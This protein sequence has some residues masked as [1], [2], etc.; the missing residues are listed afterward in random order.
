M[1]KIYALIILFLPCL[2]MGQ[3]TITTTGMPV[4][5]L[6][7]TMGTDDTY[8]DAIT[9]GGANQTWDY[10]SLQNLSTDTTG[11]ISAA[12]TPYAGSFPTANLA[13][14]DATIDAWY[15]STSD[16]T[17]FYLNGVAGPG[18]PTGSAVGYAPP[19]LFAPV[20]FTF[21]NTTTNT[22][23]IV[24]DT[25]VLSFNAKAVRNTN[26]SFL[27][28]G[29]GTLMLPSGTYN[30]VLRLKIVE[31]VRDSAYYDPLN[32]G[33]YVPVP[34]AFYTPT[35]H[36]TTNFRWVQDA[37]PGY[38]LGINGDSL[39]TT[40]T[41]SEYLA[42]FIILSNNELTSDHSSV[43]AYP[44][45]VSGIFYLNNDMK[46]Q[47]ELVITNSIGQEIDRRKISNEKL[48]RVDAVN[49]PNG[50]LLFTLTSKSGIR[51][52]KFTVQH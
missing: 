22:S 7:F 13:S 27:A 24:L 51:N 36:Q 19:L 49:Y 50:V 40:G 16:A 20:P 5:G 8:S 35:V 39:G 42:Q 31:V 46:E 2:A 12:G 1:K 43:I 21:N 11:F 17:G 28:D 34:L 10:S 45:P 52:G 4:P 25:V 37:Q 41:Y 18:S 14:Y 26:S 32:N 44:N 15:Y 38:L 48:I 23:R 3:P 30:S 6:V 33:N 29:Y 9:A 47:A